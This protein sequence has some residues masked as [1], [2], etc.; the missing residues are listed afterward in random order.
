MNKPEREELRRLCK[1]TELSCYME[2][3]SA[4]ARVAIKLIPKLLD[5]LDEA[6]KETAQQRAHVLG[7]RSHVDL[8]E[9]ILG[10]ALGYPWYKDDPKN[11]PG[12]TEK[13]GVCIGE[14][15]IE[16]LALEAANR[17]AKADKRI[18]ELERD[19]D[20]W[21]SIANDYNGPMKADQ[22]WP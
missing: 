4:F 15:V 11:F 19:R 22:R 14:H 18:A 6:D 13:D 21:K 16:T 3:W 17:L 7:W 9:Q 10:K 20:S 12:A 2:D 8:A 1:K 5:A